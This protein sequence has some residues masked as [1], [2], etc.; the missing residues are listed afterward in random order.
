MARLS[1]AHRQTCKVCRQPHKFD[2]QVPDELW[3]AVVPEHLWVV[4]VS[5]VTRPQRGWF[6]EG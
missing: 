5:F 3:A 6:A 2:F 1:D 4:G